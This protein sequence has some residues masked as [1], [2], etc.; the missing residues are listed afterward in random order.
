MLRHHRLLFVRG[1]GAIAI[2]L[3]LL[4]SLAAGTSAHFD[5]GADVYAI[6]NDAGGN[7]LAVFHRA[8]DGTLSPA[9]TVAA[10]G[11][12]TGTALGSQGAV[13]L[14]NNGRWVF[15]VDAGSNQISS[16]RVT[17]SGPTLVSVV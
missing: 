17:P 9:G 16:F 10:G 3:S 11:L 13:I 4:V 14:S 7:A 12:G 6:T 15:A 1:I 2:V 8:N 5:N